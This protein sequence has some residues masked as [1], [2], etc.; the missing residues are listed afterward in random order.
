MRGAADKAAA[1]DVRARVQ[2]VGH[3]LRRAMVEV[4]VRVGHVGVR[5]A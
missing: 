4:V 5:I 3:A 1:V 2:D